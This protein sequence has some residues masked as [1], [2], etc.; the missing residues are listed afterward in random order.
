VLKENVIQLMIVQKLYTV[1]VL[2]FV[3]I[4]LIQTLAK[5]FL[6]AKKMAVVKRIHATRPIIT[7][8]FLTSSFAF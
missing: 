7:R 6:F 3:Q 1:V 5:A 8:A 4:V 2:A